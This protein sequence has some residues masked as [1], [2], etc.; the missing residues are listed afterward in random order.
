MKKKTIIKICLGL[1]SIV[2]ILFAVLV[3]HI[4]SVIEKKTAE[5][6]NQRQLSRIDFKEHVDSTEA[7]KIKNFVASL[8]GVNGTY[9]NIPDGVL[10]YSYKMNEQ[11]S[12]DVYDKVMHFGNYKAER[13]VLSA[14]Q[15]QAMGGC[16]M[17]I[18]D[19]SFYGYLT[20]YV[21]KFLN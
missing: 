19:H 20:T 8:D 1:L 7:Y 13:Y 14:Q 2:L 17:K 21:T 9:F 4:K 5:R 15:A 11:N 12:K 18:T 6:I 3:F 10:I 16:P